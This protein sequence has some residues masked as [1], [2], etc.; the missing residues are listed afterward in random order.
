M[1]ILRQFWRALNVAL[2]QTQSSVFPPPPRVAEGGD[3]P[4]LSSSIWGCW[5]QGTE[6]PGAR[7][8]RRITRWEGRRGAQDLLQE[9]KAVGDFVEREVG[10]FPRVNLG[11]LLPALGAEGMPVSQPQ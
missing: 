4:S 6:Q 8:P 5:S 11:S 7:A 2:Q 9:P 10:I 3:A 1:S